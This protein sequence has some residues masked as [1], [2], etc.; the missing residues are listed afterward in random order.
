M[1]EG[2]GVGVEVGAFVGIPVSELGE[3]H[4][5]SIISD[6]EIPQIE[7]SSAIFE[8]NC[9]NTVVFVFVTL[10]ACKMAKFATEQYDA[11]EQTVESNELKT[12][13]I[14]PV[15]SVDA[16]IWQQTGPL[17]CVKLERQECVV[18]T[19]GL[20]NS[21]RGMLRENPMFKVF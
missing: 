12:L 4:G 10:P 9:T 20:R 19:G 14:R 17:G 1:E 16:V 11:S 7:L 18:C 5:E 2:V 6:A 15:P 21:D 8:F 13:Y 3:R